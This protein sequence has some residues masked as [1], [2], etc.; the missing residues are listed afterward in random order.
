MLSTGIALC[1]ACW[2]V[3]DLDHC[4]GCNAG[5]HNRGSNSP[6]LT[7]LT[8]DDIRSE[9][10]RERD[11]V[12]A[13]ARK[14]DWLALDDN[15]REYQRQMI[16]VDDDAVV[17]WPTSAGPWLGVDDGLGVTV[18]CWVTEKIGDEES[19]AWG[20]DEVVIPMRVEESP[21]STPSTSPTADLACRGLME[22]A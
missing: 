3:T 8:V 13:E 14:V 11:R 1:K 22:D 17:T 21:S 12:V 2:H 10:V 4:P 15:G 19:D 6:F 9:M 18:G 5:E 7:D 20:V 16:G